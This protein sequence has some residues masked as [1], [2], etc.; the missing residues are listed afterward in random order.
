MD[1]KLGGTL[2]SKKGLFRRGIN[3]NWDGWQKL[4]QSCEFGFSEEVLCLKKKKKKGG[5]AKAKTR[6]GRLETK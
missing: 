1:A 4:A 6:K 3:F 5:E 2:C